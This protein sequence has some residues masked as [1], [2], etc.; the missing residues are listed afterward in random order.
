MEVDK[1]LETARKNADNELRDIERK[2]LQHGADCPHYDDLRRRAQYLIDLKLRICSA[3]MTI[4]EVENNF[5]RLKN[6]N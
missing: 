3:R 6:P 1:M 4:M 2:L 5:T